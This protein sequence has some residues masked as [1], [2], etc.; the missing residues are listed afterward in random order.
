MSDGWEDVAVGPPATSKGGGPSEGW[1]DVAVGP[2]KKE[3]ITAGSLL[4]DLG[5]GTVGALK[6]LYNTVRHPI[7]TATAIGQHMG[8]AYNAN[9]DKLDAV[10]Q[11]ISSVLPGGNLLYNKASDYFV[12]GKAPSISDDEIHNFAKESGGFFGIPVAGKGLAVGAGG[13]LK[14]AKVASKLATLG[15]SVPTKEEALLNAFG[16]STADSKAGASTVLPMLKDLNNEGIIADSRTTNPYQAT[17]DNLQTSLDKTLGNIKTE[18]GKSGGV[19]TQDILADPDRFSH[20]KAGILTGVQQEAGSSALS[21]HNEGIIRTALGKLYP[22]LDPDVLFEAYKNADQF[23]GGQALKDKVMNANWSGQDLWDLRQGVDKNINWNAERMPAKSEAY[24]ALR[25]DLAKKLNGLGAPI[26]DMFDDASNYKKAQDSGLFEKQANAEMLGRFKDGPWLGK[27]AKALLRPG[28]AALEQLG[29]GKG[30]PSPSPMTY[31]KQLSGDTVPQKISALGDKAG[32]LGS[33]ISGRLG[34]SSPV[35]NAAAIAGAL[36]QK[37]Q[38]ARDASPQLNPPLP[39]LAPKTHTPEPSI[40][41]VS[42]QPS[43]DEKVTP[44]EIK[45]WMEGLIHAESSGNPNA[46]GPMTKYGTAKGL[47]QLI[48]STGIEYAAKLGLPYKPFDPKINRAIGTRVFSDLVDKYGDPKLAAAAFNWGRGHVDKLI[49][50]T[51]T[52]DFDKLVAHMPK[53]TRDY[54]QRISAHVARNQDLTEA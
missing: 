48:D 3:G 52:D 49:N 42:Y 25:G 12:N 18:L 10:G 22:G 20:Q 53:E 43:G 36:G 13:I 19:T 29:L 5:E 46:V 33:D 31:L 38:N 50:R 30:A 54:V 1:E 32:I 15:S 41:P 14:G 27:A 9:P 16:A 7:D 44:D 6:G 34:R 47:T 17:R 39:T 28:A 23:Q 40:K 45:P 37:I 2:P 26:G 21:T 11:G 4:S 24:T 8:E 51:G 35:S